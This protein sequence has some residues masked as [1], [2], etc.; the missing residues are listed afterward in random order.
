MKTTQIVAEE[1]VVEYLQRLSYEVDGLRVL[2]THALSAG[3]EKAQRAEIER[4]FL[5]RYA[6]YEQAKQELWAPYAAAHPNAAWNL[7]FATGVLT[8]QEPDA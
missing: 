5:E 1:K 6:E 8:V 4:E 7:D 2:H 3:V